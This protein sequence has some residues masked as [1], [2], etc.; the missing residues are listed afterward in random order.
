VP[1]SASR[2]ADEPF[3]LRFAHPYGCAGYA[4]IEDGILRKP[5]SL[6]RDGWYRTMDLGR[7]DATGRLRL[8]GRFDDS[9]KRDGF[10]VVFADIERALQRLGA[11]ERAV[12]VLGGTTA[13]GRELVAVCTTSRDVTPDV[14]TLRRMALDYLPGHAVPD[15]FLF[16]DELPLTVLAKAD[17][18]ALA[19]MIS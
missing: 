16:V 2:L 9:V 6:Y 12:I 10:L 8:A 18:K 17:R 13:R 5:R 4:D 1:P 3:P 14:T 15:R 7:V 11:I 19:A